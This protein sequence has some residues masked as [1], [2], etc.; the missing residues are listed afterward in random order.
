MVNSVLLQVKKYHLIYTNW[1]ILF[2]QSVNRSELFVQKVAYTTAGSMMR[3][4]V[5]LS[6]NKCCSATTK[7]L[8]VPAQ[9]SLSKVLASLLAS[10]PENNKYCH[11]VL[12]QSKPFR[13]FVTKEKD[14][15]IV[16]SCW[17]PSGVRAGVTSAHRLSWWHHLGEWMW[18]KHYWSL[19]APQ[20]ES[21]EST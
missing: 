1:Q 12:V 7:W 18:P 6:V 10:M 5:A 14:S 11:L 3:L 9:P 16:W 2:I 4:T 17:E 8:L 13:K 19:Q 20:A 21:K 15:L